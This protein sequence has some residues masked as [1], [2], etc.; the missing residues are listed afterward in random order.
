MN[1][2]ECAFRNI[3]CKFPKSSVQD[4]TSTTCTLCLAG[5]QIDSIELLTSAI[6]D[7]NIDA[8]EES[9]TDKYNEDIYDR[10]KNK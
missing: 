2:D 7:L 8:M 1:R 10:T 6:M 4:E 9:I 3:A 5:Q